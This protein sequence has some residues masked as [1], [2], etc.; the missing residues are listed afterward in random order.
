MKYY[1]LNTRTLQQFSVTKVCIFFSTNQTL[2][3]AQVEASLSV[4]CRGYS[5]APAPKSST[6]RHAP[7]KTRLWNLGKV[8][9]QT[10][11]FLFMSCLIMPCLA[12][13]LLLEQ[14]LQ[15]EYGSLPHSTGVFAQGG[16][17][18][19]ST[20][21]QCHRQEHSLG[22]LWRDWALFREQVL[23]GMESVSIVLFGF[24]K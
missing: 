4:T 2:S 3:F 11:K 24:L 10:E 1:T 14:E 6:A 15:R 7:L 21:S 20:H 17:R 12:S 18:G 13:L 23:L 22:P 5:K 19:Q 9:Y 8:F 16:R